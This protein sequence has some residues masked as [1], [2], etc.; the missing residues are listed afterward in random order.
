MARKTIAIDLEAYALLRSRK[1]PGQS[2][3]DVIKSEFRRSTTGRELARIV[4]NLS[5]SDSTLDAI[6]RTIASRRHS[7]AR[8]VKL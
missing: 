6:D 8:R 1:R 7:P 5:F 3:S 2:F 4:A